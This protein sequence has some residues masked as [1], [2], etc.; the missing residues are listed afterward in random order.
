MCVSVYIHIHIH[1]CI[2]RDFSAGRILYTPY[3]LI[4]LRLNI[5]CYLLAVPKNIQLAFLF[6]Q[7]LSPCFFAVPSLEGCVQK[8][9]LDHCYTLVDGQ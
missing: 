4:I 8:N 3:H 1:T 5:C 9:G 6:L 7:T 2:V